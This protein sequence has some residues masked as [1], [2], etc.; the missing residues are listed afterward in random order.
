[1]SPPAARLDQRIRPLDSPID[2][3]VEL[4]PVAARALTDQIKTG[5]EAVWQLV[6]QAYTERA[7][8]ALGYRSWD[9]YLVAEF[10]RSRLQL[11]REDRA[12][13]VSSMRES[14]LSNRAIAAA[15]GI[16]EGTVR[17]TLSDAQNYASVADPI[18]VLISEGVVADVDEYRDIMAM[19]DV[20]DEEF[21]QV[22][23]VARS[24]EDDLSRENVARICRDGTT[25]KKQIVGLDGK[26][27]PRPAPKPPQSER[28]PNRRPITDAFDTAVYDLGK[29]TQRLARLAADDRFD[30]NRSAI[31]SRR[32]SDL[33]RAGHLIDEIT[34]KVEDEVT[35]TIEDVTQYAKT[36]MAAFRQTFAP[37]RLQQLH[38][39][40]RRE[41]LLEMK[42]TIKELEKLEDD[43]VLQ[44][45]A[46]DIGKALTF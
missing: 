13:V 4:N 5:V 11:P 44:Q 45:T 20:S 34:D 26:S 42:E 17:N 31:A 6:T 14:G 3:V 39:S 32:L 30:R 28:K 1:V 36:L 25:E 10:G 43:T 27:Y 19:A 33:Q 9:D 29:V 23:A 18:D 16:S 8:A 2:A 21:D 12:E 24:E 40:D 22:L 7:W 46:E 41:F 37:H 15:T 35:D 38:A